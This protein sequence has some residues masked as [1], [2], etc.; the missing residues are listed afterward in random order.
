MKIGIIVSLKGCFVAGQNILDLVSSG[1][2]GLGL[3]VGII[4]VSS[5]EFNCITHE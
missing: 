2:M 1:V 4:L 5:S 3:G